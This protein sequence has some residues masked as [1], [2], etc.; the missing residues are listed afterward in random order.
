MLRAGFPTGLPAQHLGR[1]RIA[2]TQAGDEIQ[3]SLDQVEHPAVFRFLGD[4]ELMLQCTQRNRSL[5]LAKQDH[6]DRSA[7][8]LGA[9]EE[10]LTE[11]AEQAVLKLAIFRQLGVR[12]GHGVC[13]GRIPDAQPTMRR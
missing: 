8:G 5:T 1:K 11:P 7:V 10:R 13:D 2:D 4:I 12:G 3:R 9:A 6:H